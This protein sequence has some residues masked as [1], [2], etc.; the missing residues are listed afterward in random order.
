MV[1]S[2]ASWNGFRMPIQIA[3][4]DPDR[5][6]HQN[7]LFRQ[8]LK[9]FEAPSWVRAIVVL[10]DASY[11]AH[12]PLKLIEELGWTYV[13]AMPRTRTFPNGKHVR[14]LVQHLPKSR[15]RRR[16]TSKPD[17]K[18]QDDWVYLRYAELNE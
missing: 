10:G 9:D 15:S 8:M 3:T 5:K 12:E 16:A 6:G 17:G 1:V 7:I 13:F 2:V 4:I 18:R 14:D 11:P